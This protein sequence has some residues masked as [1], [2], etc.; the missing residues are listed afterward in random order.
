MSIPAPK[1]R[2]EAL[3]L[4]RVGA[5]ADEWINIRWVALELGIHVYELSAIEHGRVDCSAELFE[6]VTIAIDRVRRQRTP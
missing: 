4:R 2:G 1:D 5:D 6:R 3:R